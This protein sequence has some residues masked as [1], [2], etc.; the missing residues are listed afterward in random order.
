MRPGCGRPDATARTR[1]YAIGLSPLVRPSEDD[2]QQGL[3]L[4]KG[5]T[6]LG[7][8]DAVLAAAAQRW[9]WGLASADRAFGDVDGLL[10]LDLHSPSFLDQVREFS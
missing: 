2:L 9:T 3:S 7:A 6:A 5:V 4:F 10:F 8:F 1:D